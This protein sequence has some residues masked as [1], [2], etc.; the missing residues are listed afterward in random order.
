M[1]VCK[2]ILPSPEDR[3]DRGSTSYRYNIYTT[4]ISGILHPVTFV[5]ISKFDIYISVFFHDWEQC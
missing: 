4:F 1:N 2:H 5:W 3:I